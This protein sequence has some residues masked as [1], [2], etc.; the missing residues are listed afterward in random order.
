LSELRFTHWRVDRPLLEAA[1]E[2]APSLV[3]EPGPFADSVDRFFADATVE[4]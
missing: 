2:L 1:R 4:A 3:D